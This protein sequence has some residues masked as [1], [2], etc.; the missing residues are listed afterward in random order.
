MTPFLTDGWG[1]VFVVMGFSLIGFEGYEVIS[2]TAE[3]V[4]DA[5]KNVPKGIFL[6]IIIVVTTYLMVAFAVIMGGGVREGSLSA[7]FAARG[8][9]G[10]A[11]AIANIFPMGGLLA[12]LAAIFAS[13]SA[14]NAT[15][16]SSTRISF[17]LGRDG[18]LPSHF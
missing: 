6:A 2:H 17:A 13:T 18:H 15:I 4:V 7:W 8:A 10:F 12:A 16:F 11:D 3:E 1:K 5:R 9:T 14:L